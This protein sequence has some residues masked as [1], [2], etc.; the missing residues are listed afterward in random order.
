MT[1]SSSGQTY[2]GVKVSRGPLSDRVSD[3]TEMLHRFL[4]YHFFRAVFFLKSKTIKLP[5]TFKQ[6]KAVEFTADG[7]PKFKNVSTPAHE[8]VEVDFPVSEVSDL[9]SRSKALLG[10]KH[11]SLIDVLGLPP[12]MI[13]RKL[14]ISSYRAK[15]LQAE[16]EKEVY[17]E[18]MTSAQSEA[19]ME[20]TIEPAVPGSKNKK[21]AGKAAEKKEQV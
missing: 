7:K 2:G 4:V 9:E 14:G 15:R 18:L 10:V 13:S 12:S 8:L 21:S 20:Q 1:G 5:L 17:G 3:S 6:K 16:T 19:N 11:G